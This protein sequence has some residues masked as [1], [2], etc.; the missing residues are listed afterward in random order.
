[1]RARRDSGISLPEVLVASALAC[2]TLLAAAPAAARLRDAGRAGSVARSLASAFRAQRFRSVAKR[3]ACGL[4]FEKIGDGWL[5][6]DVE[7]GN[8]NGLRT[9]EIRSGADRTVVG[10]YRLESLGARVHP[11]FPRGGPFPEIPPGTGSLPSDADPIQFGSSDIVS[12]SPLG[13]SSSG[14]VYLTDGVAGLSAVVVYGPTV[15]V[16]VLRYDPQENRWVP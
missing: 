11:G 14:T 9:S 4:Y 7:D 1:M 16:R 3:R 12:F 10:P 2:A 6:S 13:S 15:R 8:G 5:V